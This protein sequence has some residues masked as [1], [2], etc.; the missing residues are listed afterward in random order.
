VDI[1]A[2]LDAQAKGS[3][4]MGVPFA[5]RR[6]WF[7]EYARRIELAMADRPRLGVGYPCPCCGYPTLEIQVRGYEICS[8]CGW[9]DDGQ[10]DPDA[11]RVWG[12]PN[13]EL[14]LSEARSNFEKY[15]EKFSP[16]QDT[17]R[18]MG[19]ISNTPAE[20]EAKQEMVAAFDSMIGEATSTALDIL[21]E[22]V[23]AGQQIL[24]EE[25]HRRVKEYEARS[26][27]R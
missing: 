24:D 12:G 25:L 10:D 19:G 7:R 3:K 13:Y 9:E 23:Y 11:D 17:V 22:Q 16:E 8:L 20:E 4:E 2:A 21:W 6:Q 14:S 26:E 18:R 1:R 27:Y 5:E 15:H